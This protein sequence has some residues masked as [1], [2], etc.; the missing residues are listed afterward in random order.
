MASRR[1]RKR[2][3]PLLTKILVGTVIAHV[4]ALPILA[5]FGAF[6][7]IKRGVADTKVVMFA[8]RAVDA[9][10]KVKEKAKPKKAEPT[11]K[12]SSG[13]LSTKSSASSLPQ[14]KLV[15][16]GP[17]EGGGGQGPTVE[18]GSG[19]A[20]VVPIDNTVKPKSPVVTPPAVKPIDPVI[21]TKPL[22]V[23]AEPTKPIVPVNVEEPK[24]ST[25]KPK[26]IVEAETIEAPEPTIPD[27][28]RS[29]PLDKILVVEADV[30]SAGH[31]TNVKITSPTGIAELDRIGLE[32]AKKY[33]F[34]PAMIDDVPTDQHVRFK[35][36]FK[37]E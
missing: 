16:S 24:P 28:F 27:E 30:D 7:N 36:Q 3:N 34:R 13:K 26:R 33:R 31:P 9:P 25:P 23:K 35:I 5:H 12:A 6:K 2:G 8:T 18:S 19:R 11:R 29:E 17:S 21:P 15:T 14:P 32:T 37:V 22:E 20:G 4:I 1:R 10:D